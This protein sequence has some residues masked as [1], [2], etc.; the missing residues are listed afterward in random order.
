[1]QA[2]KPDDILAALGMVLHLH[3]QPPI[4]RDGADHRQMIARQRDTQHRRLADRS[5]GTPRQRPKIKARLVYPDNG[6]RSL[7]AFF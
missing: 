6:A 2:Q 4:W 5:P 1:M 3:Y 7:P